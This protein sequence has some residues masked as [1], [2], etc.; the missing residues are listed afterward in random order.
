MKVLKS[1]K[2]EFR[3]DSRKKVN[4]LIN[5]FRSN[6]WQQGVREEPRF[7]PVI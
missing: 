3:K 7:R 1:P 4:H 2:E 5:I 6:S